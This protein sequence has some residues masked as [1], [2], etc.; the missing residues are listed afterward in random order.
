[1]A[2][3]LYVPE[4]QGASFYGQYMDCIRQRHVAV[5]TFIILKVNSGKAHFMLLKP[6]LLSCTRVIFFMV[7][8]LERF[9]LEN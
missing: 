5:K 4:S 6:S 8:V 9:I 1:M 3:F 7:F 2:F